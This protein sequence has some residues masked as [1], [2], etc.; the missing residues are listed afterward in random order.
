MG[1]SISLSPEPTSRSLRGDHAA[2][3]IDVEQAIAPTESSADVV[4]RCDVLR[5]LG[6][7]QL[8]LD[9]PRDATATFQQL[10]ELA[11]PFP[12]PSCRGP[13]RRG[14]RSRRPRSVRRRRDHLATARQLRHRPGR[15]RCTDRSS[16]I[17]LPPRSRA[18]AERVT[19]SALIDV[20]TRS[21]HRNARTPPMA[22]SLC[23]SADVVAGSVPCD[24]AATETGTDRTAGSSVTAVG[25]EALDGHPDA[26][27][28]LPGRDRQRE[29]GGR[30]RD[31]VPGA[32]QRGDARGEA[33][34]ARR[35]GRASG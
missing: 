18:A 34:A 15:T 24:Q 5:I 22:G 29:Q 33:G 35:S 20:L 2:A 6:D 4:I 7:T 31:L 17:I 12:I 16:N 23:L 28:E 8:A 30:A 13:R 9:R 21:L 11:L 1:T 10:I 25:L 27:R 32:E 26:E 19:V 3:R 14:R